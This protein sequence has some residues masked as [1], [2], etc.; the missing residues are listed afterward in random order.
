MCCCCCCFCCGRCHC[1]V[2]VFIPNFWSLSVQSVHPSVMFELYA[3]AIQEK[4]H[5][6]ASFFFSE[7]WCRTGRNIEEVVGEPL[8]AKQARVH[9]QGV[10]FQYQRCW[11][12]L[13]VI[14]GVARGVLV[15]C[16]IT[17]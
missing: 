8:T 10:Y 6:W 1:L 3:G 4:G 7:K 15:S 5:R 13:L 11:L 9:G 14:L 12:N 2:V 16:R 17:Y